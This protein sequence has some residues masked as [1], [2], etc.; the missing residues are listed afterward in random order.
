MESFRSP[1]VQRLGPL[2]ASSTITSHPSLQKTQ[3]NRS[4]DRSAP[5][6]LRASLRHPHV[7]MRVTAMCNLDINLLTYPYTPS[8]FVYLHEVDFEIFQLLG[9]DLVLANR[10]K[11]IGDH[12]FFEVVHDLALVEAAQDLVFLQ[13]HHADDE[14]V[15]HILAV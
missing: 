4:T 11:A 10:D 2:R 7:L 5:I 1:T 6:R 9:T 14:G 3:G 12:I 8:V 13:F 15:E